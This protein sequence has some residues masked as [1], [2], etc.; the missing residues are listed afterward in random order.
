MSSDDDEGDYTRSE[1][2]SEDEYDGTLTEKQQERKREL[3]HSAGA[4]NVRPHKVFCQ[5]CKTRKIQTK[6]LARAYPKAQTPYGSGKPLF[7][8]AGSTQIRRKLADM[9]RACG[10]KPI[11]SVRRTATLGRDPETGQPRAGRQLLRAVL[12][13]AVAKRVR[14]S[15]EGSDPEQDADSVIVAQARRPRDAARPNSNAG[16]ARSEI[17]DEG[18]SESEVIEVQRPTRS[19]NAVAGPS[20]KRS[21]ASND[22][23]DNMRASSR[24]GARAVKRPKQERPPESSS[25]EEDR[26]GDCARLMNFQVPSGAAEVNFTIKMK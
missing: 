12:Q 23:E 22:D 24:N 19:R 3:E 10:L 15:E 4:R 13:E 21:A 17:A 5:A 25:D 6:Q 2:S 14:F 18:P 26:P 11:P 20:R 9:H 8:E 16:S 1:A 7:R